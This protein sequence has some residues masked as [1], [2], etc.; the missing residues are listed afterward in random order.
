MDTEYGCCSFYLRVAM[1]TGW[2]YTIRVVYGYT[3]VRDTRCHRICRSIGHSLS[4]YV[5]VYWTLAVTILFLLFTVYPRWPLQY[6]ELGRGM[7]KTKSEVFGKH[8]NILFNESPG[9][10]P[11]YNRMLQYEYRI[12]YAIA[13]YYE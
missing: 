10:K 1:T 12:A 11:K 5:L 13:V 7:M 8:N 9:P 3:T 6:R 2:F 4:Q